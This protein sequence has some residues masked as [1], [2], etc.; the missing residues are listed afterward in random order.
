M[1]GKQGKTG[2][3]VP[4]MA[5]CCIFLAA[6]APQQ[7]VLCRTGS[8]DVCSPQRRRAA[9]DILV[10]DGLLFSLM[11]GGGEITVCSTVTDSTQCMVCKHAF[12]GH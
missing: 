6:D 5:I 4:V 10:R 2:L 9:T 1:S 12:P 3:Q 8:S 7:N 11:V